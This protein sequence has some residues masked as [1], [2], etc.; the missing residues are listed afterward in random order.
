MATVVQPRAEAGRATPRTLEE[1]EFLAEVAHLVGSARTWD[2][3]MSLIVDRATAAARAE[4]CS[5]YLMDRDG[6]GVT[7]VIEPL[8]PVGNFVSY[9]LTR[10][11]DAAD[12]IEE[13]DSPAVRILMDIYHQQITE[14]NLIPNIDL[15][16]S[17]IAYF[18]I[19][20]NPGRKEPGTGEMNYRNIFRHIYERA[21]T[22]SLR[23]RLLGLQLS[24]LG[25]FQQ[26]DLFDRDAR[27]HDVVDAIRERVCDRFD[28]QSFCRFPCHRRTR[29]VM[30]SG[31]R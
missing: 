26:L 2:E 23:I 27:V 4:V 3:L 16:W 15:A 6:K 14:G 1:L 5:L 28:V 30:T 31:D 13:V 7:L 18:Q 11:A 17:E 8:S 20:D 22:R 9:W 19:G 12:L 29:F 25:L 10:M 24:N 21:R